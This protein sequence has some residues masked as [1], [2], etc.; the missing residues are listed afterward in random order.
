MRDIPAFENH[1]F[2][3]KKTMIECLR[4]KMQFMGERYDYMTSRPDYRAGKR[5]SD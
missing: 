4:S 5:Y 3:G 2:F 1:V